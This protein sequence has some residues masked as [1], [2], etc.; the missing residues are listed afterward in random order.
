M[1]NFNSPRVYE[2]AGT[3]ILDT[4]KVLALIF[5]LSAC[6]GNAGSSTPELTSPL[7]DGSSID[8]DGDNVTDDKDLDSDSDGIP[9]SVEGL[10]DAD[11]DGT[12]NHLDLDS[13]NDDIKDIVE[14]GGMD[15]DNNGLVDGLSDVNGDGLHDSYFLSPL[16]IPDSDDDK[17]PDYLD[18]DSDDDGVLDI[19]EGIKDSDND[20][21]P[22]YLDNELSDL[23]IPP[24]L[25][26]LPPL[27]SF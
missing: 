14:A 22:D 18:L 8:T 1:C 20:G 25:P 13:D 6:G 10:S 11:I 21:I 4:G 26:P 16:P 19:D 17:L 12:P 27:P 9:D 3:V 23:I 15:I 7:G 2:K 5:F 24:T